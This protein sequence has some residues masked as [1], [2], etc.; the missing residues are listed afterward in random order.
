MKRNQTIVKAAGVFTLLLAT[1]GGAFGQAA[2]ALIDKL[3]DKG[4]LTVKEANDLRDEADNNFD[5]SYA[6]KSGMPDWVKS[7]K[8]N[9]DFRG[10]AEGFYGSEPGFVDRT[11]F[12]YRLRF[13]T[14][15]LLADNFEVG[16]RLSSSEPNAFGGDPISGNTTFT[17]NG[18]KKFV[19]IDLAYA[20]WAAVNNA[21]FSATTIL[22][23]MEN[24]F[25]FSEVLFDGDYTPEGIAEQLNF[26]LSDKHTLRGIVGGF[27]LEET[28]GDSEDTFLLGAQ[29]RLESKWTPKISTSL[30]VALLNIVDE[31]QLV[32]G[33]VPNISA[34]NTRLGTT[35]KLAYEFRPMVGDASITYLMD[36]FPTY[37]GAFPIRFG[38]EYAHNPGAPDRNNAYAV[39]VTLGKAGKKGLWELSY[40]WKTLEGDFWYEELPDSDFGAFYGTA[41]PNSAAGGYRAGTNLRGHVVR[42]IYSPYDSFSIGLT[43]FRTEV[44]D[45]FPRGSD[46]TMNR[47]QLDAVWKF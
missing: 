5:K 22:G 25:V 27:A 28:G 16:L 45:E 26:N 39:G 38:A 13:G 46:S 1:S 44:I 31:Q 3:V 14:V 23:K 24:P 33:A 18:S 7:L 10:R 12:R 19:Y 20:K 37:K 47:V 30:G 9:G 35:G 32:N 17:D 42:A 34:G 21:K 15:A 41:M 43:Y 36:K 8:F 6:V 29:L 11:R 2:D 40:K 4:I